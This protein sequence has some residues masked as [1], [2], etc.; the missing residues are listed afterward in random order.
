MH[1]ETP[2]VLRFRPLNELNLMDNFLFQTL[3]T[4]GADGEEFCRI[5]LSTILGKPFRK[6][7]VVAQQNILGFDTNLHGIR[8]DA[9]VEDISDELTL[10]GCE[11]ADAEIVPDI[12][13]IEPN[14]E[15]EKNTLP[16]RMRFYHGIIDTKHLNSGVD[17]NKLPRVVII[18]ILP[19]D[20]FGADRMIYTIKNQCVEDPSI[21]YEDGAL[22]IFLYTRGRGGNP[23][24]TLRDMLKYIEDSRIEN[25]TNKD[26][27]RIHEFV[28]KAKHRKEVGINYMKMWEEKRLIEKYAAEEGFTKG[29]KK[30]CEK[31]REEGREE[32]LLEAARILIATCQELH[33]TKEDTLLKLENGLKLSKETAR[34]AME[35]YW[36]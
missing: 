16:K 8:M 6:I 27:F 23:S 4:Q 32:A 34:A 9:Y 20:P 36:T 14:K 13:D 19:Y 21:P 10:P 5:L 15:Y 7:N 3:V 33:A 29:L 35:Q 18:I 25:V 30:G 17:Y 31:G 2:E 1:K 12:Y 24:Q 26:I 11:M 22:K 28:E